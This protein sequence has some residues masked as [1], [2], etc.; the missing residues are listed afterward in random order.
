MAR[1]QPR[2]RGNPLTDSLNASACPLRKKRHPPPFAI[3]LMARDE[4]PTGTQDQMV[5]CTNAKHQF[6]MEN[7]MNRL[8]AYP[9]TRGPKPNSEYCRR[10]GLRSN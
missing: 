10:T 1:F 6:G 5:P 7:I 3:G 2:G 8:D 4:K 9:F